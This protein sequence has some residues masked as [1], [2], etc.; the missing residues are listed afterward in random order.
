M[1]F[2]IEFCSDTKIDLGTIGKIAESRKEKEEIKKKKKLGKKEIRKK[3]R[4][5]KRNS[6]SMHSMFRSA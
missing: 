2:R 4:I 1:K 6:I 5:D 3:R